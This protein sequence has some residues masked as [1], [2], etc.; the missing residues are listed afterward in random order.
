[1][2]LTRLVVTLA[3]VACLT[4]S[5]TATNVP[6]VHCLREGGELVGQAGP[7]DIVVVDM[8]VDT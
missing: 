2:W 3:R 7:E 6:A 8:A 5:M 1:M 4:S